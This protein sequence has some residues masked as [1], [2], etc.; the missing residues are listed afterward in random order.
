MTRMSLRS[1]R[2]AE[3]CS[4]GRRARSTS[5]MRYETRGSLMGFEQR[6]EKDGLRPR[7]RI[8]HNGSSPTV[9]LGGD[10]RIGGAEPRLARRR[11]RAN[12]FIDAGLAFRAYPL[13]RA[14]RSLF[15]AARLNPL[16]MS[17]IG[18]RSSNKAPG[19]APPQP[20]PPPAPT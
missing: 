9:H 2:S 8:T 17:R 13:T 6:L 16:A 12:K 18:R 10:V 3:P 7:M 14:T 20:R 15:V 5:L 4:P 1:K 19:T 11:T